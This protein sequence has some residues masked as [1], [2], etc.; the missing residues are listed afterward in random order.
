MEPEDE[1]IAIDDGST[2]GSA[3]VL[4][5]LGDSRLRLF[6][7]DNKGAAL[8]RNKGLDEARG[9]FIAFLDADDVVLAD[10]LAKPLAVFQSEPGL[11]ILGGG[12]QVIG[13]DGAILRTER[14][15]AEDTELRWRT[16]FNSPFTAST[17]TIRAE[18]AQGLR[19]DPAVVPAEDYGFF[20][21]MLERGQGRILA[22]L[23]AQYRVHS[24][25]VTKR[26]EEALREGGNLVSA[27]KIKERLGADLA[28]PMVFLMRHLASF[29]LSKLEPDQMALAAPAQATL[30]QLFVTFRK[31]S[32]LN[33]VVLE[34]LET[35]IRKTLFA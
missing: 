23:L 26:R 24:G 17:V 6:R 13:P 35:E 30:Y 22:D 19:F 29:G 28:L 3:D 5:G 18:A 7:Q 20:A 10:R 4:A 8:A 34:A 12:F 2:D 25:Q 31:R 14:N 11:A 9:R 1:I 32:G 33:P 27:R 21:D 15:P 16:L